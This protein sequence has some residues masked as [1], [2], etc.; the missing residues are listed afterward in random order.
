MPH[1]SYLMP[2]AV[3]KIPKEDKEA[4]GGGGS[5]E[6]DVEDVE[7]AEDEASDDEGQGERSRPE[8]ATDP[9][10]SGAEDAEM[11]SPL[12]KLLKVKG[13]RPSAKLD[14]SE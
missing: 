8:A 5:S 11:P 3:H 4:S 12:E 10:E 1:A 6:E 2:H 9:K 7:D 14:A 13:R